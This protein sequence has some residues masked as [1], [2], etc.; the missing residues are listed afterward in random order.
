MFGNPAGFNLLSSRLRAGREVQVNG[1]TLSRA[2]FARR[3]V[4]H[5]A[6]EIVTLQWRP[7]HQIMEG[8]NEADAGRLRQLFASR[9][10][11]YPGRVGKAADLGD[12]SVGKFSGLPLYAPAC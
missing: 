8:G 12:R 3:Q 2:A 10:Q 1:E 11:Q 9:L 7:N 4:L 6:W 5:G